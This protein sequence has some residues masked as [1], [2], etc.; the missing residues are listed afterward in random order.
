MTWWEKE[1][2]GREEIWSSGTNNLFSMQKCSSLSHI[3]K[4]FM[5]GQ[6]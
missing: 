4:N 6:K 5:N 3:T 2:R 1:E